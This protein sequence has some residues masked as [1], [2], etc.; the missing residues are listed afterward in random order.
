MYYKI[1]SNF[2]WE[3]ICKFKDDIYTILNVMINVVEQFVKQNFLKKDN[4]LDSNCIIKNNRI[5]LICSQK[6]I[7]TFNFPF[8]IKEGGIL[9]DGEIIDIYIIKAVERI[10]TIF[11][12]TDSYE[13]FFFEYDSI[14]ESEGFKIDEIQLASK[15]LKKLFEIEIGYLRYDEDE[16]SADEHG[17]SIH[18]KYHLD[19]FFDK[20]ISCK[21]GI[22]KNKFNFNRDIEKL[23]EKLFYSKKEKFFLS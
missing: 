12:K 3:N 1:K 9:F 22:S 5:Y 6:K 4:F 20:D 13:T 2:F 17:E 16:I 18:P 14:D 15:I 19:I 21:I 10:I 7:F 11:E 23:F 8:E